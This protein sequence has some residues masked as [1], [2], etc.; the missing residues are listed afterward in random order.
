MNELARKLRQEIER[1]GSIPFARFMEM[2]LYEPGL[3]YYEQPGRIGRGGDFFTSAST[4][5]VFGQLLAFQFAQWLDSECPEERFQIV[6]AGAHDARLAADILEWFGRHRPDLVRRLEYRIVE[7]SATRRAW[8]EATLHSWQPNVKWTADIGDFG[9]RGINGIVFSNEFFDAFPVYRLAWNANES[10]WREWRVVAAQEVFAW[11]LDEPDAALDSWLPSV[12]ASLGN[13]VPDGFVTEISPAAVKW[14]RAAGQA[15]RR[16]KLLTFDYGFNVGNWLR[17]DRPNGTLRAFAKHHASADLL[18]QPG[19]QD[20]TADVNFFALEEA[21]RAVGLEAG[22]LVRQ[23]EFLT[24]ILAEIHA[25]PE[26][27]A[28]WDQ[29][30]A[31]QFQT[32]THPEHLGNRFHVLI[33]GPARNHHETR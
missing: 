7:P 3:G 14:W 19:E 27:F 11:K 9:E 29:K 17:P 22:V 16:G 15:L 31:R 13:V 24:R 18:A 10:R 20:L 30:C 28:P 26:A 33:Q 25:T 32:L 1:D 21:A 6:E 5:P 12:P 2:A 23:S 4:G 8:Q